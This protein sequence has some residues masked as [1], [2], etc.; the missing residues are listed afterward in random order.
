MRVTGSEGSLCL[1]V[2]LKRK[3]KHLFVLVYCKHPN[4]S[5]GTCAESVK[6][7]PVTVLCWIGVGV[8]VATGVSLKAA[9][10]PCYLTRL[11]DISG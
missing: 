10:P 4:K 5:K 7:Q 9:T 1:S 6:V 3:K 8:S 2:G 11:I